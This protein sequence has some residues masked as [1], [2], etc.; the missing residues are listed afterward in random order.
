MNEEPTANDQ[1]GEQVLFS[2]P[3]G[4]PSSGQ[5]ELLCEAPTHH[6]PDFRARPGKEEP[7]A[8]P[9]PS[10]S[11]SRSSQGRELPQPLQSITSGGRPSSLP[12][13][14]F[15]PDAEAPAKPYPWNA[16]P[17]AAVS[18]G[19]FSAET[20]GQGTGLIHLQ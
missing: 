7:G 10:K 4:K 20:W 14:T 13:L 6:H 5:E 16:S 12:G 11:H 8:G 2:E 19:C 3:P 15:T 18:S 9:P 1:A 17:E